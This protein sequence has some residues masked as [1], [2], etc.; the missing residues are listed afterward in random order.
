MKK[1]ILPLFA[2]LVVGLISYASSSD[3]VSSQDSR[4]ILKDEAVAGGCY[5]IIIEVDGVEYITS[6]RG[7]ICPLVK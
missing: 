3:E 4:I 5:Y 1:I 6:G 2:I 7:G